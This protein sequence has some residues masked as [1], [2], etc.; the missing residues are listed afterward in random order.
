MLGL[1]RK[2]GYLLTRLQ[3]LLYKFK[4]NNTH[5]QFE[6]LHTIY[7]TDPW[8]RG[9]GWIIR[10]SCV[11]ERDRWTSHGMS[12]NPMGLWD[13]VESRTHASVEGQVDIPWKVPW[14][15]GMG[16]TIPCNSMGP[17]DGMDNLRHFWT[18]LIIHDPSLTTTIC[19]MS[20]HIICIV[21]CLG[22]ISPS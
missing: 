22:K 8:D 9:M 18:A 21:K 2:K 10:Y 12:Y 5:Y 1:I 16:W 14:Y 4:K 13:G 19:T 3:T 15:C 7:F 6:M 11:S 20:S 17:W